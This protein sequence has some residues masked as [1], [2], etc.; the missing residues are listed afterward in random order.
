MLF[1]GGALRAQSTP[2]AAELSALTRAAQ[3]CDN[4]GDTKCLE[5][6]ADRIVALCVEHE[7]YAMA[8]DSG[9]S[10]FLM[11]YYRKDDPLGIES[12]TQETIDLVDRY[13]GKFR[14]PAYEQAVR[15]DL[16]L[17]LGWIAG[18]MGD[19]DRRRKVLERLYENVQSREGDHREQLLDLSARLSSLYLNLGDFPLAIE[20]AERARSLDREVAALKE[21]APILETVLDNYVAKAY[22][23]QKNFGKAEKFYRSSQEGIL[24]ME[25][26]SGPR[27]QGRLTTAY[28]GQAQAALGRKDF[29]AARE[30][31]ERALEIDRAN[32]WGPSISYYYLGKVERAAGR[33]QQAE[34]DLRRSIGKEEE[35]TWAD[36]DVAKAQLE[37]GELY[38]E[39]GQTEP[40]LNTFQD[41]LRNLV[42]L[43]DGAEPCQNPRAEELIYAHRE[44]LQVLRAKTRAQVQYA[45]ADSERLQCALET[46]ELAVQTLNHLKRGLD[47][48]KVRSKLIADNYDLFETGI[49]IALALEREDLAMELAEQSSSNQLL[50]AVLATRIPSDLLPE[51]ERERERALKLKLEMANASI[52]ESEGQP[53]TAAYNTASSTRLELETFYRTLRSDF[54]E[55][56][57]LLR[58]VD[59]DEYPAI[60]SGV[61]QGEMLLSYFVGEEKSY[62]FLLRPGQEVF[63]FP[64]GAGR[65]RLSTLVTELLRS[66]YFGRPEA[67]APAVGGRGLTP[68]SR[69]EADALFAE[70]AHELYKLLLQPAMEG[71]QAGNDRLLIVPDGALS[72]LPFD[73]LL[74]KEVPEKE[75]GIYGNDSYAY[76]AREFETSYAYSATLHRLMRE[77]QVPAGQSG[78]LLFHGLDF[79]DQSETIRS[80]FEEAGF[81][82]DYVEVL[83]QEGS[84]NAL[85]DRGK[86]HQVVHFSVHGVINGDDPAFSYLQLRSSGTGSMSDSL[87]SLSRLYALELPVEMVFT[88]ACNAGVGRLYE[89]EGVLSLARGFAYAGAKSLV[90]TLWAVSGGASNQLLADF[91]Q[92]L[93]DG[94]RKDEALFTAKQKM[95]GRGEY[96]HPY[97]WAGFIPVGDMAPLTKEPCW[98]CWLFWGLAIVAFVG[99]F[100]WRRRS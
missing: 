44:L 62:G 45:G 4:E 42:P 34:A 41:A 89:G 46:H 36:V 7:A 19:Q 50:S 85:V 94:A 99:G 57:E 25:D 66:I 17:T 91:Y 24:K 78:V 6:Y 54:P 90:T 35:R 98:N 71:V 87:L 67:N 9:R 15:D 68:R 88:S 21:S 11:H 48:E 65:N 10:M 22:L 12:S 82:A 29:A 8:I 73:V 53:D 52:A 28:Q 20:Y 74:Q 100:I 95:L 32:V 69:E 18:E 77:A 81:G 37:L 70:R 40:A 56:Y 27:M 14:D 63:V 33:P 5:E 47:S 64:I 97:Y 26:Y 55:Y 38:L 79:D 39:T 59:A 92:E 83:D 96:A 80:A 86:D 72:Y 93:G 76:L 51:A 1:A 43:F 2:P 31:L 30:Y 58:R 3:S 23:L 16:E 13:R 84:V 61:G 60:K 49:A 75:L